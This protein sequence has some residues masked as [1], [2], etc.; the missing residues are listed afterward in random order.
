MV[1]T[2][3]CKKEIKDLLR[4][5]IVK[6]ID[7]YSSETEYKPFFQAIFNEKQITTASIIQSFYTS[8]GMSIYE[9]IAVIIAKSKGFHAERQYVLEGEI[10]KD[11][12]AVIRKRH[13]K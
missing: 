10:D 6:K 11:T 1:L 13:H 3:E 2:A 8:F 7:N 4:D 12:E 9:Q 5:K